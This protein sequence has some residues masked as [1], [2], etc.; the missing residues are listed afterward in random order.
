M[1]I[2][3]PVTAFLKLTHAIPPAAAS[4]PARDLTQGEAR[5]LVV[6]YVLTG[7]LSLEKPIAFGK[8]GNPTFPRVGE[9]VPLGL[10]I[11]GV[12]FVP[13]N[14][15]AAGWT[16]TGPMDMRTAVLAVRLAQYLKSRWG[17]T[18][19]FWGGMGVGRADTDRHGKGYA[20]DFHGAI[21]RTGKLDVSEDWG[22][23]PITLPDGT[24]A[25]KWPVTA[26][27]YFRLDVDT[28]AGAFFYDVYRWL[29]GEA[30]DSSRKRTSIGDH[31]YI[32]CPDMP[33][34]AWRDL[35]QDHIHCEIDR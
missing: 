28:R 19:I 9:K 15:K 31:S 4:K 13:D 26:R 20:I 7:Q 29:T 2:P 30:A 32:L 23:Q 35:H 6:S 11:G 3:D 33:D 5:D 34:V 24:K 22:K 25:A 10:G 8:D 1:S 17:V 16:R 21:T 14:K 12:D 18:T 27:P